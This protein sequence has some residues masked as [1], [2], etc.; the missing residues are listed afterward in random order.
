MHFFENFG[1][2]LWFLDYFLESASS[3][4]L[5]LSKM[6]AYDGEIFV[7]NALPILL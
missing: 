6:F 7:P 1:R 4:A 3:L 5:N 2:S